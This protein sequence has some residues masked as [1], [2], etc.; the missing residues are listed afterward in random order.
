MD[1]R[2]K[3]KQDMEVALRAALEKGEFTVHYQPQ[4]DLETG[5]IIGV[6]ALTRWT[7]PQ[8]GNVSPADVH[9]RGRRNRV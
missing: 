5:D 4:V 1:A 8:L 6:E 2:I 9:S 7:H 3:N